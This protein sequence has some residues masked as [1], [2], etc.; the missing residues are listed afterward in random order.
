MR[1]C[2]FQPALILLFFPPI[3]KYA[4]LGVLSLGVHLM[5]INRQMQ[6]LHRGPRGLLTA[7][8]MR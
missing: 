1:C 7:L 8:R 6:R 2:T 4:L 3:P 5:Q